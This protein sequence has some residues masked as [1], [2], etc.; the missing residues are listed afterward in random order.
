MADVITY[1]IDPNDP[2][3]MYG[4]TEKPDHEWKIWLRHSGHCY[5]YVDGQFVLHHSL[6]ACMQHLESLTE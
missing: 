3:C 2:D 5:L 6:E 4:R 1:P